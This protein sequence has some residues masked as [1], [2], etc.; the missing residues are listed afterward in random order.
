MTEV[1]QV[2]AVVAAAAYPEVSDRDDAEWIEGDLRPLAPEPEVDLAVPEAASQ[3]EQGLLEPTAVASEV[4]AELVQAVSPAVSVSV[5]AV[6]PGSGPGL[7]AQPLRHQLGKILHSVQA[8]HL[9]GQ[10]QQKLVSG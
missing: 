1:L 5:A 2:A 3:V 7:A 10:A 8:D 4:A 9:P 6:V